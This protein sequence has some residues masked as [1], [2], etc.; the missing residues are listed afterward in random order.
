MSNVIDHVNRSA[1]FGP[2]T[3]QSKIQALSANVPVMATPFAVAAGAT[4]GAAGF[5]IGWGVGE[6]TD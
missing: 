1:L 3:P 2:L 4:I 5:G 6:V